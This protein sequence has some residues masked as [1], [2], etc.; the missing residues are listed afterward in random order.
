MARLWDV[1]TGKNLHVLE[2]HEGFVNA[3]AF[4]PGGKL[5]VTGG[6]DGTIRVWDVATGRQLRKVQAHQM[7]KRQDGD[8]RRDIFS[9]AF[10]PDGQMLASGGRDTAVK[11]WAV[12]SLLK[13]R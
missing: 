12:R 5:L 7:G 4:F 11:V 9:L 10:S 13:Q 1:S 3:V 2:G 6:E 8:R